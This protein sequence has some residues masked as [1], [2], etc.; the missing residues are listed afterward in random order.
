MSSENL[1]VAKREGVGTLA[2]KK[3]RGSG[4]VPAILYGHGEENVNL[5]VSSDAIGKVI[6]HGTKLL[7]LTGDLAETALLRDVQ[8]DAFGIEVLHIDLTRVSQS[9]S[10]EVALPVELHGEAAGT[11]EG[12]ILAFV[13]HSLTI[14]CPA[15]SIP[16]SLKVTI[17][18]LHMGQAIHA[19]EVELPEGASMVTNG[20]DVVVQVTKPTGMQGSATDEEADEAE[21]E[22]I[23]KDG[24]DEGEGD[25]KE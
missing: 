7:A 3:L 6:Q 5:S 10:V 13:S 11:N 12:G 1:E 9:E 18:D 25:A 22:L 14:A 15:S 21:P 24:G 8:W 4:R 17:T 20:T 19:N 16:D 2:A 23:R